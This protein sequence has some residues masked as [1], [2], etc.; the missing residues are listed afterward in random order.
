MAAGLTNIFFFGVVIIL[1]MGV[2]YGGSD[3]KNNEYNALNLSM[4]NFKK[5]KIELEKQIEKCDRN[6]TG[7]SKNVLKDIKLT[8]DEWKISLFVLSSKAED[9]CER[10]TRGDFVIAV[11]I[12]RETAKHYGKKATLTDPYSENMMFGHYWKKLEMKAKY[13]NIPEK[14]RKKLESISKFSKPFH[15]FKTL[16]NLGIE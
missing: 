4:N 3:D 11:S 15:L 1:Y 14:K 16:T 7:I 12:Y 2:C 8:D 9:I 6:K 5:A 10:G 13:L